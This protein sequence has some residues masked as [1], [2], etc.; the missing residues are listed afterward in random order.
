LTREMKQD[1]IVL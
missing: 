1:K